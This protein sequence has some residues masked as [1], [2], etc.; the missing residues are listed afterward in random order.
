MAHKWPRNNAN[1]SK[2]PNTE[3]VIDGLIF[4]RETVLHTMQEEKVNQKE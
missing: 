3:V 4:D 1:T 2:T